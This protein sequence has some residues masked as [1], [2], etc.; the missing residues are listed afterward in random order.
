M[1]VRREHARC[2]RFTVGYDKKPGHVP[3]D[4]SASVLAGGSFRLAGRGLATIH[5]D[6]AGH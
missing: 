4:A 2:R 1:G 6:R 3:Q 5:V